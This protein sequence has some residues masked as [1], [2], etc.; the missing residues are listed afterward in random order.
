MLKVGKNFELYKKQDILAIL[1]LSLPKFFIFS[2]II[3]NICTLLGDWSTLGLY[4][5]VSENKKRSRITL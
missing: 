2:I 4:T 5:I 1:E 3:I